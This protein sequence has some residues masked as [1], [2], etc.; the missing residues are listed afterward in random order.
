MGKYEDF[1]RV[2]LD[3]GEQ[4]TTSAFVEAQ[5]SRARA[6]TLPG[7]TPDS[8]M[9]LVLTNHRLLLI[10]RGL[11]GPKVAGELPLH[12]YTDGSQLMMGRDML[13]RPTLEVSWTPMHESGT[14]FLFKRKDEDRAK[15]ILNA[16][17]ER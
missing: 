7:R 12:S 15:Q 13:L 17:A 11:S 3:D 6:M 9:F 2:Q 4:I 14:R 1:A 8:T 5:S 16:L 10:R